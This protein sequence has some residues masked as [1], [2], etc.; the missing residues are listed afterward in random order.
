[1]ITDSI[2]IPLS[3]LTKKRRYGL[4]TTPKTKEKKEWSK[5][6]GGEERGKVGVIG[7][8]MKGI[9][10]NEPSQKVSLHPCLLRRE[11]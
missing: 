11:L 2:S 4:L 5:K 6:E 1:M 10:G 8:V 7:E 9:G 3:K